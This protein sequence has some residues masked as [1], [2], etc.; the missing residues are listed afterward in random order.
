MGSVLS[1]ESREFDGQW[2]MFSVLSLI[3]LCG[4]LPGVV[5]NCYISGCKIFNLR[6]NVG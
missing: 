3:G 4:Q 2:H 5:S 6:V 1:K